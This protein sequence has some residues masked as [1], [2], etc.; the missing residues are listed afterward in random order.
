MIISEV[1][2]LCYVMLCYVTL[3]YVTSRHVTSRHV[4]SH[5]IT[6][7]H[8][9]SHYIISYY[10]FVKISFQTASPQSNMSWIINK[11]IVLSK[12][13]Y[14]NIYFPRKHEIIKYIIVI[15]L[16]DIS[17]TKWKE[18]EIARLARFD[19]PFVIAGAKHVA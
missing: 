7:H 11:V 5:H 8:I 6:S 4:T 9:T 15:L 16:L 2:M 19:F 18:S 14:F 12:I 10:I 13:K 3:R 1:I 17:L